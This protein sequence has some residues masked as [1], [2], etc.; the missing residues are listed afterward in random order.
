MKVSIIALHQAAYDKISEFPTAANVIISDFYVD[1]LITGS[2]SIENTIKLKH[3]IQNILS[4]SG[5]ILTQ[6]MSNDL[7]ILDKSE[8][9]Q[10]AKYYIL[11][12][13]NVKTL[14]ILWNPSQDSFQ[15][16][17]HAFSDAS[18]SA[19]YGSCIYIR[20]QNQRRETFVSLLCAKSR[21]APLKSISIPR[22]ELCGALLSARLTVKVL[23]S[24]KIPPERVIFWTDSM[25]TF[26]AHTFVSN[27]VS[28]IQQ[29]TSEY[30]WRHVKS[31]HNPADSFSRGCSVNHLLKGSIWFNGPDWLSLPE[32]QWEESKYDD[33]HAYDSDLPELKPVIVNHSNLDSNQKFNIF[34][35]YS[36]LSE[37]L[38][39]VAFC[40]RFITNCRCPVGQRNFSIHLTVSE[41]DAATKRLI[42]LIQDQAFYHD[43]HT[44]RKTQSTMT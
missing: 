38:G 42:K 39:V 43:I 32:D 25:R 18:Q 41:I 36:S 33:N 3:D 6:W 34:N 11:D 35:K 5:F 28:E 22:L 7:S 44:L 23:D 29:K 26:R 19:Y 17:I 8:Q 10:I 2:T 30:E 40:L 15:Y 1:D 37:L 4:S 13:S 20:S 21:V 12:D 31:D 14:G 16:S 27:R 24:L 9:N